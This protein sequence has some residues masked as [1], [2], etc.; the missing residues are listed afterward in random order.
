MNHRV[1][2][3][4]GRLFNPSMHIGSALKDAGYTTMWVGKYLNQVNSYSAADW[5]RDGSGWTHFDAINEL[6]GEFFNYNLHTKAGQMQVTTHSTRMVAER[7]AMHIAE[8]PDDQPRFRSNVDLQHAWPG[9]ANARVQERSALHGHTTVLDA[10]LQRVG[11][12]RQATVDAGVAAAELP[13]WLAD[14]Q[15][16]PS[17]ADR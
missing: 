15:L 13:R 5:Q 7:T 9:P 14:G 1:L 11:H 2:I 3:N 4:D 8:A 6:N 12:E 10:Q 16:L 17:D